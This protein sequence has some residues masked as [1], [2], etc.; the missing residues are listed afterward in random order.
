MESLAR[1]DLP[2]D[3]QTDCC[4]TWMHDT[5][6]DIVV[7]Y[8]FSFLM[9]LYFFF[10]CLMHLINNSNIIANIFIFVFTIRLKKNGGCHNESLKKKKGWLF[11][12][13]RAKIGL[14]NSW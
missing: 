5:I 6:L 12:Y 9:Y 4:V 14:F 11:F 3:Y 1:I 2:E 7:C 10:P 8:F 13:I